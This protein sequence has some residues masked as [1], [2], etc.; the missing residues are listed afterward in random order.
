MSTS[1]SSKE[2]LLAGFVYNPVAAIVGEPQ[3]DSLAKLNAQLIRN[4]STVPSRL[5][6]GAYGLS[7][8]VEQ[9][10]LYFLRTNQHFNRPLDPGPA[11]I[12]AAGADAAV[13][14][15]RQNQWETQYHEFQNIKN[16]ETLLLTQ[17][18]H[19]VETPYLASIHNY[20]YGFGA[21]TVQDVMAWLFRTYGRISTHDLQQNGLR[22]NQPGDPTAPIAMIFKQVDEGQKFAAA[23]GCPFTPAQIV[24]CALNLILQTGRY[25]DTYKEWLRKPAHQQ[26]YLELKRVFTEAY[27]L[28]NQIHQTATDAGFA[29]MG[30]VQ[31]HPD[32]RSIASA[33]QDFA[34]AEAQRNAAL[35]E[36]TA[37]NGHLN[38]QVAN[39]TQHN[40]QLQAQLTAMQHQMVL[41]TTTT[42]PPG[43][44][45][46]AYTPPNQQQHGGNNRQHNRSSAQ[47]PQ[48]FVPL[49]GAPAPAPPSAPPAWQQWTPP[50][51]QRNTQ[52]PPRNKKYQNLNYCWTHGADIQD[53][54]TGYT[55][56]HP[57]TGHRPDATRNN[58]MGGSTKGLDRPYT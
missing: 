24:Q 14:T 23:A 33:A 44:A 38:G 56:R 27:Q 26:T 41:L 54:H 36:L 43:S 18:E 6:G 8:I 39:L 45:P 11:P 29:N 10:A 57:A 49:P 15:N 17:I 47:P 7:G 21:R 46:P 1:T 22:M 48:G 19:A 32:D 25:T 35:A 52:R 34:A 2:H 42:Q 9:P 12:F 3:Y 37:T 20:E 16:T 5:G 28:N 13:R 51:Q 53:A 30:V 31:E 55:C 58:Q 40:Q 4:A 50:S